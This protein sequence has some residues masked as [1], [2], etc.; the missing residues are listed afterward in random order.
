MNNVSSLARHCRRQDNTVD[1]P[2][3]VQIISREGAW[4]QD[5]AL[6][7]SQRRDSGRPYQSQFIDLYV[8]LLAVLS[9]GLALDG[10]PRRDRGRSNRKCFFARKRFKTAQKRFGFLSPWPGRCRS[11]MEVN[12]PA[13]MVAVPALMLGKEL[14]WRGVLGF[15]IA[16]QGIRL[17]IVKPHV[18][19]R[20]LLVPVEELPCDGV[21]LRQHFVR[22]L[23]PAD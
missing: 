10:N 19:H 3:I 17:R 13:G 12:A 11:V 21:I 16:D 20:Q 7:A 2:E 1:G 15:H 18:R 6:S 4:R 5:I 8:L 23:Q 22:G 14:L 9:V